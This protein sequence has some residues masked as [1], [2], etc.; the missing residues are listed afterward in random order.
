MY[1]QEEE[2][3]KA[4][5]K[6]YTYKDIFDMEDRDAW[7]SFGKMRVSTKPT[8]PQFSFTKTQRGRAGKL[9]LS[10]EI[11]KAANVGTEGAPPQYDTR[12]SDKYYMKNIPAYSIPN[13]ER[14]LNLSKVKYAYYGRMDTDSDLKAADDSR[15]WSPCR[16]TIGNERKFFSP[17][18]RTSTP[19]PDH[20]SPGPKPDLPSTP[21]Y[22]L[23]YRRTIKGQDSIL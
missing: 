19:G 7:G 2:K 14:N 21:K 15:R 9:F 1:G 18:K 22:T 17:F 12:S 23:G 3:P 13:Q 11:T 10:K 16:A 5:P 20:Y 6:I 4:V 8:S